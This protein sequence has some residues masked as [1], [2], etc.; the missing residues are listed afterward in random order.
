MRRHG[1]VLL[2]TLALPL[3]QQHSQRPWRAPTRPRRSGPSR[4]TH[5]P[6][7]RRST[8][9]GTS[10]RLSRT[11]PGTP[12]SGCAGQAEPEAQRV[13]ATRRTSNLH[14]AQKRL[15]E[16][17]YSVYVNGTPSTVDVLAGAHSLS[18]IIDRAESAEAVSNQD[19]ALGKQALP[20]STRCRRRSG[21]ST[22]EASARRT[23]PQRW[24]RSSGSQSELAQQKRLLA[25]ID[26]TISQLQA[27][28]AARERAA[29]AA[30]LRTACGLGSG[31]A[32]RP[33]REPLRRSRNRRGPHDFNAAAAGQHPD[34]EP[35]RRPSPGGLDRPPVPRGSLRLGRREP[36]SASTAPAS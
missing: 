36:E 25:S 2:C 24:R 17:L 19:A 10:C 15:M 23:R 32:E 28:Q 11:R 33:Q 34:R 20:S 12:S 8:R 1:L 9:S 22:A 13:S 14:A 27:Q 29:R 26:T 18:Q 31:R 3:S 21:N 7:S 16:R 5:A 35:R 6:S 30:A 4:R